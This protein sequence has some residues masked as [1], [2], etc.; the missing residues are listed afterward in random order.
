MVVSANGF[1]NAYGGPVFN[2][3]VQY[4]VHLGDYL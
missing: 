1:F 2:D 3:D 4:V